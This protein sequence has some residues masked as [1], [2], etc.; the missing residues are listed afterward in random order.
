[1]RLVRAKNGHNPAAETVGGYADRKLNLALRAE[2][3]MGVV[4]VVAEVQILL[5]DYAHVK[6]RMHACYRAARGDF[7]FTQPGAADE[8]PRAVRD[9]SVVET[10]A[11]DAAYL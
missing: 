10:R 2:T 8:R 1:M 11:G 5:T 9:L 3:P 6:K 7:H 4:S